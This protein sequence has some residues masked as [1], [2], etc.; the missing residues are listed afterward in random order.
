MRFA[1][2]DQTKGISIVFVCLLEL[3]P[4]LA[5][6]SDSS[7]E[8]AVNLN[9]TKNVTT[10]KSG[11]STINLEHYIINN[12][13]AASSAND[14]RVDNK[15]P[16][17][18]RRRK[19]HKR[20]KTKKNLLQQLKRKES[21]STPEPAA[22]SSTAP[23]KRKRKLKQRKNRKNLKRK[24]PKL[25]HNNILEV[26]T[27][28]EM[29]FATNTNSN[30]TINELIRKLN[31]NPEDNF[32]EFRPLQ[33]SNKNSAVEV[34]AL[35]NNNNLT[36]HV[37]IGNGTS[38]KAPTKRFNRCRRNKGGCTHLCN[39][40][41]KAK[42]SCLKGF[43]LAPDQRTCLD[44]DECLVENGGCESNCL[45]TLGAYECRCPAGLRLADDFKSCEDI[46][47]C[48]L[49]KGHGPCQDTCTNTFG[50]YKCSCTGL[51]GTFLAGNGHSC[52]DV[53]ECV[54]DNGGCSHKCIN[55]PGT[56]FCACPEAMELSSDWK[57]C[58]SLE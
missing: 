49:R 11:N 24:H 35:R 51:D 10:S 50:S 54:Q 17:V 7:T 32:E 46:N 41:G 45:N 38:T 21:T 44:I 48:L 15:N 2:N 29:I 47:E 39:P 20:R 33:D 30:S 31:E 27:A 43:V 26:T 52:E 57:T 53:D 28:K 3:L 18:A 34:A 8:A 25:E 16:G 37:S 40:K 22:P 14:T 9:E 42:C 36:L 1:V 19:K 13:S 58:R 56:A 55:A 6:Q 5:L 12:E 4:A 23:T